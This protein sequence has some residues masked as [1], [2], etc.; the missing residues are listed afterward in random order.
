[1]I[2]LLDCNYLCRRAQKTTGQLTN[3]TLFGFLK[4]LL[5]LHERFQPETVVFAFDAGKS[6]RQEIYPPYKANRSR[7]RGRFTEMERD[8]EAE[9]FQQLFDLRKKWLYKIGYRNV[10]SAAGYEADDL[11][12]MV[13]KHWIGDKTIVATDKDFYQLLA[14]AVEMWNPIGHTIF[15]AE[16][17]KNLY[18]LNPADWIKVKAMAGCASD[19]IRGVGG[20]GE[21]TAIKYLRGQLPP[22]SLGAKMIEKGAERIEENKKIIRLPLEGTPIFNMQKDEVTPAGWDKTMEKLGLKS[23]RGV[24]PGKRRRRVLFGE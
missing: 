11:I 10:F 24:V 1:M 21:I 14:P 8:A 15:T 17:F 6:L 4:E 2:L 7:G 12:G 19:N 9:F 5:L 3:G 23:L 18:G 13:C 22:T 20:V 16:G